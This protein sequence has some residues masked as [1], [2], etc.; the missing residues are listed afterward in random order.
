MVYDFSGYATRND[1]RCSDGLTIRKDAF[2]DQD[3]VT[4]PL[5]WNHQHNEVDN[6]LGHAVLENRDDGVYAYGTFNDTPS[7]QNAKRLVTNGDI[8]SLS[9]WANQLQKHNG[10]DV[11]HGVIREVSLVLS[12]ANPGAYID[13]VL[14]HSEDGESVEDGAIIYSGE[15]I[16]AHNDDKKDDSLKVDDKNDSNKEDASNAK[17]D[18][19][20]KNDTKDD[21]NE[22]IIDIINTMTDKQKDAMYQIIG[23]AAIDLENEMKKPDA[24]DKNKDDN[25]GSEMK[26]NVFDST[27]AVKDEHI[28]HS[29][30]LAILKMAKQS[31]VGSLQNALQIYAQ[32]N[33]SLAHAFTDSDMENYLFPD[34]EDVQKGE[35]DTLTRD[36]SWVST[37]MNGVHKSPFSR[38]RT[39]QVDARGTELRGRGYGKGKEKKLIGNPALLSRTTDPQTIYVK[40]SIHRDDI[41]DITEFDAVAYLKKLMR[42]NLEEEVATA[43]LIGDGRTE[44]VE[45]KIS[46]SHIRSIWNDDELYTI[47][48]DVDFDAAKKELQGSNTSAN[49]GDNYVTA[50]AMITASLHSR[51]Q[52]KGSGNVTFFCTPHVLNTMLLARDLNGRRIYNSQADLTA[53]LNVSK[54]ETVEQ[55]EGLTRTTT[56][57]KKKELLGIFVNLADYHVGSTKGGEITSFQ[58]FDIDF[59]KEKCL[60]ETRISGA[61]TKV[62]SAIALE[63]DVTTSVAG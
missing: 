8:E 5:V 27:D 12:G 35:P 29:D 38:I 60:M 63:K 7:G 46:E 40:D 50:E 26:H 61:L 11:M 34:Y 20:D 4:V 16:I 58:Q 31:N 45:D 62:Y 10:T 18:H 17:D 22:T 25:G 32:E 9:I 43:I 48:Y 54:I 44:G 13:E 24:N 57:S 51:E 52:Y 49:F 6:V 59:N 2:K 28:A 53:A 42:M 33:D 47:H 30:E 21:A 19:V 41:V 55:F 15:E 56:D 39:R 23:Q 1:L 3:G 14:A 37:V 36:Q